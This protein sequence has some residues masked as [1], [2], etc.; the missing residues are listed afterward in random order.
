M[1]DWRKEVTNISMI[2]TFNSHG[3]SMS[4]N[5]SRTSRTVSGRIG[6]R[7]IAGVLL[8]ILTERSMSDADVVEKLRI[9]MLLRV[10][11]PFNVLMVDRTAAAVRWVRAKCSI[12]ATTR[13]SD[14]AE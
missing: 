1:L 3:Y 14:G 2:A 9:L 4:S 6:G 12:N 7:W 10:S 8:L 5:L 11:T 13:A